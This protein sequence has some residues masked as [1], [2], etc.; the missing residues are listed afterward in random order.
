MNSISSGQSDIKP[1]CLK[2]QQLN[3]LKSSYKITSC[4]EKLRNT[5]KQTGSCLLIG[6]SATGMEVCVQVKPVKPVKPVQC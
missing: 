5:V 6:S 4:K 3:R 1:P 2:H